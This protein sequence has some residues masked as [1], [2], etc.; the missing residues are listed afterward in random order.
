MESWRPIVGYEGVYEVSS[1]GRIRS[2]ARVVN[3]RF[4]KARML[5]LSGSHKDGYSRFTPYSQGRGKS[6]TVHRI[7]LE[8]FVGPRPPGCECRHIDGD[9]ANNR[10]ENLCW[11]TKAENERDKALHGNTN[12]GSTNGRARLTEECV[13]EIRRAHV[14]GEGKRALA[15]RY[16]VTPPTIRDAIRG[17]TWKHLK[18]GILHD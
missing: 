13:L 17:V 18:E 16:G 11:G 6:R 14:G 10:I 9:R 1:C 2:V 12:R 8:A 5:K 15:R 3:R 7:V 4:L